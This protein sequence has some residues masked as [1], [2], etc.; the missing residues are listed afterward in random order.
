MSAYF[1]FL[2]FILHFRIQIHWFL[3]LISLAYLTTFKL[4]WYC[5][6][7]P[8]ML[9]TQ[10]EDASFNMIL[11]FCFVQWNDDSRMMYVVLNISSGF[12][13]GIW[14]DIWGSAV[15][16]QKSGLKRLNFTIKIIHFFG[17]SQGVLQ[18]QLF[19]LLMWSSQHISLGSDLYCHM[20]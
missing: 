12:K 17:S 9:L 8:A 3:L 5:S 16:H 2:F 18:T 6:P 13:N 10:A 15:R 20:W 4:H 19:L 14:L 11:C 7:F 1:M